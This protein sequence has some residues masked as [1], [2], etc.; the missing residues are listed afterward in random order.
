MFIW[1]LYLDK[2]T[3]EP[4][5]GY[6]GTE[7]VDATKTIEHKLIPVVG[8]QFEGAIIKEVDCKEDRYFV[9]LECNR[10]YFLSR[11]LGEPEGDLLSRE[12]H[13]TL[14]E[15]GRAGRDGWVHS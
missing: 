10:S 1:E 2:A 12:W 7:A 6:S 5:D 9:T 15:L 11:L 8:A 13:K 4:N 3:L 14:S